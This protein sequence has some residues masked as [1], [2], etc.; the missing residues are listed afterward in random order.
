M[1]PAYTISYEPREMCGEAGYDWK[2]TA[3]DYAF[4]GGKLVA[5]GWTR[6]KRKNAE[7]DARE[8]IRNRDALRSAA[9][10]VA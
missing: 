10:L 2:I 9:G 7:A 4:L 5:E 6:G 3:K 1:K 8:A